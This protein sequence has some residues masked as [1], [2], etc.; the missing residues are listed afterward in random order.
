[1]HVRINCTAM[2][3]V[4]GFWYPSRLLAGQLFRLQKTSSS[5]WSLLFGQRLPIV[6]FD[7]R[8]ETSLHLFLFTSRQSSEMEEEP[9]HYYAAIVS[10]QSIASAVH[11]CLRSPILIRFEQELSSLLRNGNLGLRFRGDREA[12]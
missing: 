6:G 1:M 12:R 8:L 11:S 4:K 2:L 3:F 10:T 5:S 9:S 7:S